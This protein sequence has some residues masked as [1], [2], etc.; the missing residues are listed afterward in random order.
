MGV[1]WCVGM[2]GVVSKLPREDRSLLIQLGYEV[3]L[4]VSLQVS[5]VAQITPQTPEISFI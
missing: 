1:N 3:G 4:H 2:V 5:A